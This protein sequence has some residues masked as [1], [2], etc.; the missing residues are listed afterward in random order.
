MDQFI[1]AEKYVGIGRY[2]VHE[3]LAAVAEV[4]FKTLSDAEKFMGN[5]EPGAIEI[6]SKEQNILVISVLDIA[7]VHKKLRDA[8]II[9]Y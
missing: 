9:L 2:I 6:L 7:P 8:G 5:C 1:K 4:Y 3:P